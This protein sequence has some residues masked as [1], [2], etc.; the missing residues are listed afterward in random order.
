MI[1][2]TLD[3]VSFDLPAIGGVLKDTS[4]NGLDPTLKTAVEQMRELLG[5][6]PSSPQNAAEISKIA[7]EIDAEEKIKAFLD[8]SSKEKQPNREAVLG[9][10]SKHGVTEAVIAEAPIGLRA[11]IESLQ[12]SQLK[13]G[14]NLKE[15]YQQKIS[16]HITVLAKQVEA[17]KKF[18][19]T[20]GTFAGRSKEFA[21]NLG[22]GCRVELIET[23]LKANPPN[24]QNAIAMAKGWVEGCEVVKQ[25]SGLN[26]NFVH[27]LKGY[28]E[29]CKSIQKE[30]TALS[31][32]IV[33]L[34]DDSRPRLK[35]P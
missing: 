10:L 4:L 11:K 16:P 6:S 3:R 21:S 14:V 13:E 5:S 19:Q 31:N 26:S 7:Q 30:L 15:V 18:A 8:A 24:F 34:S 29:A 28:E 27:I 22:N 2:L 25:T 20:G 1:L 35:G 12:Q 32:P 9:L 17:L 33:S 23:Y